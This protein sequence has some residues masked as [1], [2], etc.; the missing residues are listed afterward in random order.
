[1]AQATRP[2][3]IGAVGAALTNLQMACAS[4]PLGTDREQQSMK[5][6]TRPLHLR[7]HAAARWT[8]MCDR[9]TAIP[10]L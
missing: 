2:L 8:E 9:E 1:M 5:N 7:A 3:H 6:A 4:P 10:P